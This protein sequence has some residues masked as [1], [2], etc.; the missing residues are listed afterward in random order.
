MGSSKDVHYAT[1]DIPNRKCQG[2]KLTFLHVKC[3]HVSI[4]EASDIVGKLYSSSR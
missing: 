1:E 2:I 3:R 4:P